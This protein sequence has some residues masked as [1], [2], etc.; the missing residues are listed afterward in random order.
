MKLISKKGDFHGEVADSWRLKPKYRASTQAQKTLRDIYEQDLHLLCGC[1]GNAL[2]FIRKL[3]SGYILVNHPIKGRHSANCAFATEISGEIN[4]SI[5]NGQQ[6]Y[7]RIISFNLHSSAESVSFSDEKTVR[8]NVTNSVSSKNKL[9]N[10]LMQLVLDSFNH[11][12]FKTK[13]VN[14][15]SSLAAIRKAA[16]EIAFG[17]STLDKFVFYGGKGSLMAE[18]M[19]L[20][21]SWDGPKKRH[22]FIFEV[23]D[24]IEVLNINS[25]LFDKE[26][27]F[28]SKIIRPGNQNTKGPYLIVSSVIINDGDVYRHTCVIKPIVSKYLLMP[29]DSDYE[30][31]AALTMIGL[32][33]ESHDSYTLT[34]PI[35]PR[36][37]EENETL[38]P[39]F[40]INKKNG[41]SIVNT[42]LIEVMGYDDDEYVNRKERLVPKM[43]SAWKATKV[44]EVR[45]SNT[46]IEIKNNWPLA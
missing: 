39:D 20:S 16:R 13:K 5:N 41:K 35:K 21:K 37:S 26:E 22:V 38:L 2:M 7:E 10:L 45:G 33:K 34:K 4:T 30:R 42:V 23:V 29:I 31:N 18:Q 24:T 1:T 14:V 8:N 11:T 27:R 25:L 28:Y 46:I 3:S 9:H 44:I 32:I 15:I 6:E 12:F 19:L 43:K 17:N 36:F 40:V